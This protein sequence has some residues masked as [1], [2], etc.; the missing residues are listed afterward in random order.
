[1][2]AFK[3]FVIGVNVLCYASIALSAWFL[4]DGMFS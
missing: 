2:L 3:A 4:L 1:M